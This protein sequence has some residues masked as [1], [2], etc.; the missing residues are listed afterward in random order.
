MYVKKLIIEK[1]VD[2]LA[3]ESATVHMAAKADSN[4]KK[5]HKG[6]KPENGGEEDEGF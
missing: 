4:K 2:E 3:R 6:E 5:N 1:I